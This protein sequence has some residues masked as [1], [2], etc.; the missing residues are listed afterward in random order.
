MR[1]LIAFTGRARSGKDT[2]AEIISNRFLE[3]EENSISFSFAGILKD[4]VHQSTGISSGDA[5]TLKDTPA[6][7]PI[8]GLT[9]R[10]FYNSLGDVLK[11]YMGD[12]LWARLTLSNISNI[13]E[14]TGLDLAICT[15]LR[16]PIEQESLRQWCEINDFKLTVI[17][18]KNLNMIQ[19]SDNLSQE[20]HESEYL[21]DQIK[22]DYLIEA[23]SVEEI[24]EQT[25]KIYNEIHKESGENDESTSTTTISKST[26]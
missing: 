21:V 6:V 8:N 26:V 20:E 4:I 25:I 3:T 22:E 13:I 16:Y 23:H 9:V 19:R 5:D 1:R 7:K 12:D 2:A 10:Q 14:M 15:D 17:K 11:R 24:R 18:M